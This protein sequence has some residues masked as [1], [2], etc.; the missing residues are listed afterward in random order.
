MGDQDRHEDGPLALFS[1]V[2]LSFGVVDENVT[3]STSFFTEELRSKSAFELVEGGVQC[4]FLLPFSRRLLPLPLVREQQCADLLYTRQVVTV[5][6]ACTDQGEDVGD[7][8]ESPV[9]NN[10]QTNDVV[11]II[12]QASTIKPERLFTVR[13]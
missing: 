9:H 4:K 8:T 10:D 2:S 6:H 3:L 5:R 13:G 1:N 11:P 7:H 12:T